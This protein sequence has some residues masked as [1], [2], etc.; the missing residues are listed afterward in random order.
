MAARGMR[1]RGL[2][3]AYKP[4]LSGRIKRLR[5]EEQDTLI[6][7]YDVAYEVMERNGWHKGRALNDLDD[8]YNRLR[9]V[10]QQ[11]GDPDVRYQMEV[12]ED[13]QS[14][15]GFTSPRELQGWPGLRDEKI[16]KYGL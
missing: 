10:Y 12:N 6:M 3:R 11:S 1:T 14:L 8:Q 13:V 2:V 9:L 7:L 4:L 5:T 16:R 15:I